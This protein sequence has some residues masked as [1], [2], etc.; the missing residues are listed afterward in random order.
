MH[1]F[2]FFDFFTFFLAPLPLK[3]LPKRL[4]LNHQTPCFSCEILVCLVCINWTKFLV[5]VSRTSFLDG[6]L[7]SSVMGLRPV[8]NVCRGPKNYSYATEAHIK[9]VYRAVCQTVTFNTV[10]CPCNGLVRE[11]SP[12]TSH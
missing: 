3:R 4:R 9:L 5:R 11:V 1:R 10:R 12:E 7:G 2:R 6:E 8:A